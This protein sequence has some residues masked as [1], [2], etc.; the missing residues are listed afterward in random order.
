[1]PDRDDPSPFDT[2]FDLVQGLAGHLAGVALDTS[3]RIEI[4]G[5]L[6]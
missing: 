1:M 5:V 2:P 3:V 4:K 6:F